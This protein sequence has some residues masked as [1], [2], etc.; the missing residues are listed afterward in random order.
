MPFAQHK[1]PSHNSP[2]LSGWTAEPA[3]MCSWVFG[4]SCKY[5]ANKVIEVDIAVGE[6]DRNDSLTH[7]V[8]WAKRG[9]RG[10]LV[11]LNNECGLRTNTVLHLASARLPLTSSFPPISTCQTCDVHS[12]RRSSR[13]CVFTWNAPNFEGYAVDSPVCIWRVYSTIVCVSIPVWFYYSPPLCIDRSRK[14]PFVFFFMHLFREP[15][16][17][18]WVVAI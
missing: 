10:G 7:I 13:V 15:S 1:H 8:I 16:L 12:L 3:P 14:V 11:L 6:S 9:D 2:E 17:Q 18:G 4:R 5:T